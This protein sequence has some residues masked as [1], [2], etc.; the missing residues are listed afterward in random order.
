MDKFSKNDSLGWHI[1]VLSNTMSSMLDEQLRAFDLKLAY[2][3]T[4]LLLWEQEGQTQTELTNAC[5][6][7]HYTTTRILDKLESSQLVERRTDPDNRRIF[8]IFL[9]EK[10]RKLEKPLTEIA[11]QVNQ[12]ILSKIEQCDRDQFIGILK[13][14]NNV[15]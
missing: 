12:H 1:A 3:P 15:Y 11:N 6:T 13:T 9:T 2:W 14:L 4:L 5:Q 8:R 10:G 7:N